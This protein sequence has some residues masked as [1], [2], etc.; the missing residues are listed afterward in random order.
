MLPRRFTNFLAFAVSGALQPALNLALLPIFAALLGPEQMGIIAYVDGIIFFVAVASALG[1]HHY[2]LRNYRSE[3]PELLFASLSKFLLLHNLAIWLVFIT[4]ALLFTDGTERLCFLVAG[5]TNFAV[6]VLILPLR[7]LRIQERGLAYGGTY[8]AQ[9]IAQALLALLLVALG[10]G[11]LGRFVGY[12]LGI[13]PFALYFGRK[14]ISRFRQPADRKMIE[15]AVHL[16]VALSL[17][18]LSMMVVGVADRILLKAYVP[19]S[20][21]GVYSVGYTIGFALALVGAALY[22]TFEPLLYAAKDQGEEFARH[23]KRSFAVG[24]MVILFGCT[25]LVAFAGPLIHLLLEAEFYGAIPI[26]QIVAPIAL[27][28]LCHLFFSLVGVR[29]QAKRA[30]LI[31]TA[32]AALTNIA[33]NLIAIPVFGIEGA[34]YATCAA[35]LAMMLLYAFVLSPY[36]EIRGVYITALAVPLVLLGSSWVT[37]SEGITPVVAT[38]AGGCLGIAW[39]GFS[40]GVW[41]WLLSGEW[42]DQSLERLSESTATKPSSPRET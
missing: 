23:F 13:L 32:A 24:Y 36:R 29:L 11:V 17:S 2:F 42:R 30:L 39:M 40:G 41:K 34:A 8:A 33:A 28:Q 5:T 14:T 7:E 27:Y 10:W 35:Y 22:T 37:P 31:V 6:A 21:I 18:A 4:V 20:E 38:L 26:V 15:R 12:F 9:G 3:D 1:I 25:L 19:F 16:G